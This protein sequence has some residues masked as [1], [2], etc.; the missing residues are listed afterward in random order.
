MRPEVCVWNAGRSA[1][2]DKGA[3]AYLS[4]LTIEQCCMYDVALDPVGSPSIH[5]Q[6]IHVNMYEPRFKED[7]AS[8]LIGCR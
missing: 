8:C 5:Y 3:A 7:C 2:H 1:N 6:P 4:L